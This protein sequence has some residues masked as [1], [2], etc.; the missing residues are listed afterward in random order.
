MH[1][2]TCPPQRA[3]RTNTQKRGSVR[4]FNHKPPTSPLQLALTHCQP[5]SLV[6]Y[7][8][9]CSQKPFL[10]I[11]VH[12]LWFSAQT[13]LNVACLF[14]SFSRQTVITSSTRLKE[15]CG[16]SL[17]CFSVCLCHCEIE[18]LHYAVEDAELFLS[19]WNAYWLLLWRRFT[20]LSYNLSL[21][22][23]YRG[24]QVIPAHF[25]SNVFKAPI[26]RNV[27]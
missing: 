2:H 24:Y 26:S 7:F 10:L 23:K 3:L 25:S 27:L 9:K 19:N 5:T 1:T 11:I 20:F 16:L 17:P 15:L 13:E 18:T 6:C 4:V 22:H 12:H 8:K 14:E 21:K